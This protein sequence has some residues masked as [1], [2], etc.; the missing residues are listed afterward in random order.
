MEKKITTIRIEDLPEDISKIPKDAEII[1]S[2]H[3]EAME[4]SYWED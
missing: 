4:D 3:E 2:D 1:V